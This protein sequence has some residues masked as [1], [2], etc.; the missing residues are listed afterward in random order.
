MPSKQA[1]LFLSAVFF[2]FAFLRV[3]AQDVPKLEL[4]IREKITVEA[5][6]LS[7]TLASSSPV[8]DGAGNI[9]LQPAPADNRAQ[10]VTRIS[11]DGQHV[12]I[13]SLDSVPGL[14]AG[15]IIDSFAVT[16][17]GEVFALAFDGETNQ[18]ITFRD[19]GQ[20]DSARKIDREI[21]SSHFAVFPTGEFLLRG[22]EESASPVKT[23]EDAFTGLFDRNGKFLKEVAISDELP[24][25]S[26]AEF[27][28]REEFRKQDR[29]AREA[30][31]SSQ[32][33]SADDGNVYIV[34]PSKSLSVDVVSPGGEV[35]RRLTLKPPGLSFQAGSLKVAGGK[36]VV[37]YFQKAA[38]DP[39]NRISNIIYSILDAESG[40]RLYDYS[41]PA[42]AGGIFACYTPDSFT[43]LQAGERGL[44]ILHAGPR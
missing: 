27:T 30:V 22:I 26:R 4:T 7:P 19:D 38:G 1:T 43:F 40:D 3:H 31:S 33:I 10:P 8:C 35:V 32:T 2:P 29:A 44:N 39:Q 23:H 15:S 11:A 34:R 5:A 16:P 21:D 12:T 14:S 41:W 37:E 24:F 18:L 9:Y 13:F 20:F 25:K 6:G 17:R 42:E 36:F 28:E